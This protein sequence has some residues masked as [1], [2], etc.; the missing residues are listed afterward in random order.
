MKKIRVSDIIGKVK[1]CIDEI[2][3]NDAEF[4]GE[5][6]NSEME[7]IIREKIAEAIR[8][9]IRNAE[10]EYLEPDTV[11]TE[12]D[13]AGMTVDDR[14]VGH[15]SLPDNFLRVCYARFGSWPV[16]VTD[17]ILWGEKEYAMLQDSYTTGTWER[18]KIALVD[19]PANVLELYSARTA[20]ETWKVGLITEPEIEGDDED[21]TVNLPGRLIPALVYYLAGLTLLTY[22]EQRADDMFNQALV[23]MGADTA[24]TNANN[25]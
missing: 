21:G 5:Q 16:Y 23:H 20:D 9:V 14:L 2:A 11:L 25:A 17:V 1:I 6:D 22:N 19:T 10:M 12:A 13:G 8:Y 15:L 7:S 4:T 24:Q 3:L 18:P